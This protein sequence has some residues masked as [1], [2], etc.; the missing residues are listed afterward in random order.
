[1]L[2]LRSI[3]QQISQ[4]FRGMSVKVS[5]RMYRSSAVF[6]AGAAVITVIAFTS[7]G[8]GSSGKNALTA[9]A[10]T[11]AL[12]DATDDENVEE[13]ETASQAK[14]QINL[15]DPKM[16]AQ[17]LAGNLLEKEVIQKQ[18]LEEESFTRVQR[19]N[20]QIALEEEAKRQAQKAAEEAKKAEEEAAKKAEE[21]KAVHATSV[22]DEDYNVLLKIVQAEA[23]IC[24]DEGK[25][26]VANVILNRVK[27]G[28]FPS[29]VK[30]V[31]YSPS[32]FSP[33]S[34]GSINSVKVTSNTIECVNRA[35]EGEDYS[36]G[37]LYFMNRRGSR[38]GAISWFDSHLT[39][40]F[41]HG[42]HEFFK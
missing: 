39:Y 12:E 7:T 10:E 17:Q 29:T 41:Q 13:E 31:V 25:I 3:L 37:A 21:E 30:G 36:N 8:F 22:S 23:G 15:T 2:T 18:E 1:M 14:V 33:V 6:M 40:L 26:L 27:S 20:E 11:R 28:K 24:D 4:F 42:N 38:S 9:F 16:Q 5:K 35:L 34:D 32:Q 19:M